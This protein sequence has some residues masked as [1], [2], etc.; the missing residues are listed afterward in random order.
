MQDVDGRE[1]ELIN[2]LEGASYVLIVSYATLI[3]P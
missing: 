3:S 1:R 2:A